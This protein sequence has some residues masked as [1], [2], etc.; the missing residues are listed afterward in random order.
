MQSYKKTY[1]NLKNIFIM[2]KMQLKKLKLKK[3]NI[4]WLR[5]P[6]NIKRHKKL[7]IYRKNKIVHARIIKLL[8]QY[9]NV[10]KKS[11]KMQLIKRKK[12]KRK[13]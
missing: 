1:E 13:T 3:R 11:S 2:R 9:N 8:H 12:E 10:R 5:K 6:Q 4:N 7:W